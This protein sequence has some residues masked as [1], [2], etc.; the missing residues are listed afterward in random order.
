[1]VH[2]GDNILLGGERLHWHTYFVRIERSVPSAGCYVWYAAHPFSTFH[3]VFRAQAE[4]KGFG[5]VS[6]YE[7]KIGTFF[8]MRLHDTSRPKVKE[9]SKEG[10]LC[11]KIPARY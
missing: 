9:V 4:K 10:Y 2:T 3:I 11:R 8:A 6:R 7:K 5:S 1:M